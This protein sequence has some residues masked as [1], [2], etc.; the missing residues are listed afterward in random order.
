ML[1]INKYICKIKKNNLYFNL[2][3]FFLN[4]TA[5]AYEIN[6]YKIL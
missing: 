6:P 3:Y 2:N 4:I 1:Y 5:T